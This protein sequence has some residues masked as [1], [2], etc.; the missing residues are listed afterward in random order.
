MFV[1]MAGCCRHIWL[2]DDASRCKVGFRSLS[3]AC[4]R[5]GGGKAATCFAVELFGAKWLCASRCQNLLRLVAVQPQQWAALSNW[6]VRKLEDL[7][8]QMKELTSCVEHL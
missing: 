2:K 3:S 5:Q 7:H 4:R 1:E 6:A 8:G